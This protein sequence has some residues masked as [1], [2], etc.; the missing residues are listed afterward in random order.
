L[1]H[2]RRRLF[3]GSQQQWWRRPT[4]LPRPLETLPFSQPYFRFPTEQLSKLS[5]GKAF[6]PTPSLFRSVG[7]F[8]VYVGKYYSKHCLLGTVS[9]LLAITNFHVSYYTFITVVANLPR[10]IY[11]DCVTRFSIFFYQE[12]PPPNRFKYGWK[13]Q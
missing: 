4:S 10:F 3:P 8:V 12:P 9:K 7:Y 2:V 5:A 1:M 6:L 11:V 13:L